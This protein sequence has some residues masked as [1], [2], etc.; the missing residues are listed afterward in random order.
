M[1]QFVQYLGN[2]L[3]QE[4]GDD[5]RRCFVGAQT[6]L[7][8]RT[9]D[10]GF[11]QAVMPLDSHQHVHQERDELQV[12]VGVL[13]RCQKIDT[14]IGCHRPVAVF[15]AA[16]DARIRLLMEQYAEM[17]ALCHALHNAHNEQV[18]VVSQINILIDRRHLK[19]VRRHLVM[20]RAHGYACA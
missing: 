11:E 15:A 4:D 7:V 13:A 14:R 1:F 3:A 16:V 19:L 18:M 8:G 6:V 5:S 2:L 10:R 12:L 17:V 20:S 9:H